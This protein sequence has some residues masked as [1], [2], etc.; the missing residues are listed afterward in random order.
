MRMLHIAAL[1]GLACIPDNGPT[2]RPGDDCLRC[3]GGHPGGPETGPVQHATS[4]SLAGTVY[5]IAGAGPDE[6]VQGARVKVT[7][8]K[9]FVF[10][11]ETNLVGNFYSAETVAL[12]LIV[13]VERNGV[14][15]C[16]EAPA[17]SGA[18]NYCHTVPPNQNAPGHIAA[19]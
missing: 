1:L 5:A 2:M 16:M 17:P 15:Q 10:E 7:D 9:G 6:G 3:H 14:T 8:A 12:P 11:V 19:P 13:C 18:C 4:W